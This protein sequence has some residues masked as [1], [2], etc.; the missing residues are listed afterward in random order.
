MKKLYYTTNVVTLGKDTY[1]LAEYAK[2]DIEVKVYEISNF[3]LTLI[4]RETLDWSDFNFP[5]V[6]QHLSKEFSNY[7]LIKL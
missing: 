4:N 6:H 3:E 7:Q 5:N 2:G 1:P